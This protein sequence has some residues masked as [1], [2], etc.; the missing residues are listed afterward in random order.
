MPSELAGCQY[1]LIA[2]LHNSTGQMATR[3]MSLALAIGV[4]ATS[5]ALAIADLISAVG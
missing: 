4:P 2:A 5:I 1:Q 3:S